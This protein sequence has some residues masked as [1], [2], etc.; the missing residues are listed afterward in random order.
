MSTTGANFTSPIHPSVPL[1]SPEFSQEIHPNIGGLHGETLDQKS[2]SESDATH[3]G[4]AEGRSEV[5]YPESTGRQSQRATS[6]RASTATR[7]VEDNRSQPAEK[8]TG[9]RW[10]IFSRFFKRTDLPIT[11]PFHH[12]PLTLAGLFLELQT[13]GTIH[14]RPS[15]PPQHVAPRT[16]VSLPPAPHAE[17]PASP[18]KPRKPLEGMEVICAQIVCRLVPEVTY[19]DIWDLAGEGKK[20]CLFQHNRSQ[21]TLALPLETLCVS[22]IQRKVRE[23]NERFFGHGD[24]HE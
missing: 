6:G 21:S 9:G 17:I 23:A 7:V 18:Y 19:L 5:V 1:S 4:E 10:R 8:A 3:D 16:P 11:A 24:T 22:Q 12:Q 13:L 15:F 20:L 14:E 2:G